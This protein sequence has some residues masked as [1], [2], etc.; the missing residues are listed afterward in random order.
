[1]DYLL[2]PEESEMVGSEIR[3]HQIDLRLGTELI[4]ILGDEEGIARAAV[5]SSGEEIPCGFVGLTAGVRP[6]VRVLDGSAIETDRGVLVND[7]FETSAPDVYA[8]GDCVQFRNPEVAHRPVEQLWYTGRRHGK[9]VARSICGT[10]TPYDRG[11]FFNSAKFFTIEYQTYGDIRSE[12]PDRHETVVWQSEDAKRLLRIN[13][14]RA[15]KAVVGFNAMGV[16]LRH[17]RCEQ[18]I[19]QGASIDTVLGS[20]ASLNFDPEMQKASLPANGVMLVSRP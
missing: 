7:Y 13:Y 8:A 3:E 12:T 6:N 5:T 20:L 15:S 19:R 9:T 4:E 16:R 11:V 10:R 2:P 17:E 1:M 14:E 18:L